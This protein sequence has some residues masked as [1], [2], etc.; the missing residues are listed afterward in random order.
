MGLIFAKM[1]GGTLSYALYAP[2]LEVL[3]QVSSSR[4]ISF[5]FLKWEFD[6]SRVR[7]HVLFFN[8]S[9]NFICA[10][11]ASKLGSDWALRL[12]GISFLNILKLLMAYILFAIVF[13]KALEDQSLNNHA[14]CE[15]TIKLCELFEFFSLSRR[16]DDFFRR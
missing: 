15:S 9:S 16:S 6:E 14:D 12:W 8:V 5:W 7:G 10:T 1:N 13:F 11:R 2:V 3:A 4:M